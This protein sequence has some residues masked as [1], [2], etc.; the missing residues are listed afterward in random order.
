MKGLVRCLERS[1]GVK[2]QS[3]FLSP[4]GQSWMWSPRPPRR[5]VAEV[6]RSTRAEQLEALGSGHLG[7]LWE[8]VLST[9]SLGQRRLSEPSIDHGP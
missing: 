5:M 2:L 1:A 8:G 4:Y 3:L 9:K 7:S 6:P